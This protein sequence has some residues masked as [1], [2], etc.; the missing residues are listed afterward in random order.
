MN[1]LKLSNLW[2]SISRNGDNSIIIGD[3]AVF[4]Y[5]GMSN[6]RWGF[7][8]HG[9]FSQ[10]K[11]QTEPEEI[12][13]MGKHL[14]I[15]SQPVYLSNGSN[16]IY[17]LIQRKMREKEHYLTLVNDVG[18][19][20]SDDDYIKMIT[21]EWYVDESGLSYEVHP[22]YQTSSNESLYKLIA[23]VEVENNKITDLKQ[24]RT[25]IFCV[26]RLTIFKSVF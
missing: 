22:D 3:G 15:N 19:A 24:I 23:E 8:Y 11:D 17:L 7:G 10:K 6:I 16:K 21:Q 25:G 14:F 2:F 1:T 18:S 13:N 12:D 20:I 26:G 4:V 5:N 9:I